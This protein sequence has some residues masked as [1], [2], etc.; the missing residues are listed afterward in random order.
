[1]KTFTSMVGGKVTYGNQLD[2]VAKRAFGDKF[3]GVF[4]S[5][6]IPK[7]TDG[8]SAIINLDTS[9]QPGSHWIAIGK[10]GPKIIVYDSFGRK[11]KQILPKLL[12]HHIDTEYDAE[13]SVDEYNCGA[14]TLAFLYVFHNYGADSRWV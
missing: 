5:D 3:V 1:M 10:L 9:R 2:M 13:Q 7:L 4:S 12:A 6:Q 14:R 8:Q 11:T